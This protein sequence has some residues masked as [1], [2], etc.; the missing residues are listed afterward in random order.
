MFRGMHGLTMPPLSQHD[1]SSFLFRCAASMNVLI[2]QSLCERSVS[3]LLHVFCA[4]YEHLARQLFII[5][6]SSTVQRVVC[7]FDS[8]RTI[9]PMALRSCF[10]GPGQHNTRDLPTALY[11]NGLIRY[12]A[13]TRFANCSLSVCR[14]GEQPMNVGPAAFASPQR[15][16]GSFLSDE[17]NNV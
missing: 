4:R 8:T 1:R 16:C 9:E 12:W 6:G 7:L 14:G 10:G 5:T 13:S 15:L 17:D 2:L 3:V 11:T